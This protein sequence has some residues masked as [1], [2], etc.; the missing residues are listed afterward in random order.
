MRPIT[1]IVAYYRLSQPHR[2]K[3]KGETIRDAYG[4]EVQRRA[5]AQFAAECNVPI[6]GEFTEIA[7]GRKDTWRR[8]ELTRALSVVR[9]H[10]A[11]LV[12]GK[13]D[14][15]ARSV[16]I[17]SGLLESGID[18]VSADR[19]NQTKCE[20]LFRAIID[21]E[22]ADS[23][24]DRTKRG[25]QIAKEKGKKLGSARPG[26]WDGREHLRGFKQATAASARARTKRSREGYQVVIELIVKWQAE[27]APYEVIAERLNALN[28]VTMGNKPFTFGA[29]RQVMKLFGKEPVRH[30]FILAVC[31]EC[32]REVRVPTDRDADL[33]IVCHRC[34]SDAVLV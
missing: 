20:M 32:H 8:K 26:H 6:I 3:S 16:R 21:A 12:V 10:N 1:K 34:Q 30:P 22:E 23:V 25:L 33:P 19:P 9:S 11:T 29:V 5:V 27:G 17:I 18:F 28:Y 31:C 2:G 7:S 4:L 24:A 15:L 14:R 13:Q